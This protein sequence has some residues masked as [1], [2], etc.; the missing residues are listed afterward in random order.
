[1]AGNISTKLRSR[2]WLVIA[3]VALLAAAGGYWFYSKYISAGDATYDEYLSCVKSG[4]QASTSGNKLTC[5]SK[6]GNEVSYASKGQA[7]T[8]EWKTYQDSRVNFNYPPDWSVSQSTKLTALGPKVTGFKFT[9]NEEYASISTEG[10]LPKSISGIF[11]Y[12]DYNNGSKLNQKLK[13][14]SVVAVKDLTF[15]RL[16]QKAQ[17]VIS[18]TDGDSKADLITVGDTSVKVGDKSIPLFLTVPGRLQVYLSANLVDSKGNKELNGKQ[19]QITDTTSFL[20]TNALNSLIFMVAS[21]DLS[22]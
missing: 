11:A 15:T 13:V 1:M 12:N 17:L 7:K 4:G 16:L 18:D 5:K 19:Y 9:T 20:N 22:D 10:D 6:G 14:S 2:K 21:V 3:V 8:V